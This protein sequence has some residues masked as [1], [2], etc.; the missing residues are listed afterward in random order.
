MKFATKSD[1]YIITYCVNGKV[2]FKGV[3]NKKQF[4]L[5]ES[6]LIQLIELGRIILL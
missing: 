6:E 1:E 4:S 5:P 3:M 2:D